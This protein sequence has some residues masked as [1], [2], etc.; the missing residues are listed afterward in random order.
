[1]EHQRDTPSYSGT[2]DVASQLPP[3]NHWRW[4]SSF[5][6][7]RAHHATHRRYLSHISTPGVLH[8]PQLREVRITLAGNS[9]FSHQGTA[10]RQTPG[11]VI[12]FDEGESRDKLL[13][14]GIPSYD[15]LWLHFPSREYL[16][17]NTHSI[18][19]TGEVIRVLPYGL[20]RA[21]EIS[22]LIQ[23]AWDR[24]RS[25]P[26]HPLIWEHLKSLIASICL[27]I[28]TTNTP[29]RN[30][31]SHGELVSTLTSYIES[32][33]Q[34]DL[35]LSKL[36][37]MAGYSQCFIHRLFLRYTGNTPK[38]LA[39]SSRFRHAKKLLADHYTVEAI[40]VMVGF[41][42]VSHFS[43]FFKKQA[44]VSPGKW[45]DLQSN[46]SNSSF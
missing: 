36:A 3:P 21:G 25:E 8:S 15:S 23:D 16:L 20:I 14:A 19:S 12:L 22:R 26:D 11:S 9:L 45:R 5:R 44:G 43:T 4:I 29:F 24:S 27:E 32:H 30:T 10:Y 41:S 46:L 35:S 39:T 13:F 2:I 42:S 38:Q 18:T 28:L 17:F 6:T 33:P 1:M 7:E 34:E 40:S 31:S 37:S